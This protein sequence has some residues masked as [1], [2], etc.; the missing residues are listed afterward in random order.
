[1]GVIDPASNKVVSEVLV[2]RD[3]QAIT[4]GAGS[5]WVANVGDETVQ[6]IDPADTAA[7]GATIPVDDYPSDLAVGG[8]SVW[9]ALGALA[10]LVRINP[11][12]NKTASPISALG[13]ETPCGAPRASVAFGGGFV[14]FACEGGAVGRTNARK[15]VS[16]SIASELA[17]SSSSVLPEFSDIA[18][19]LGS[20]WIAN[21]AG[22]RVVELDPLTTQKRQE[23]SVGQAPEAIAVGAD[24]LW[25]AN[26]D[27]DTVT[28]IAI[29]GPGQ[30]ATT[31]EFPVGD[32]PIDV[33]VGEGAVWIVSTLDRKLTRLD[34]ETGDV[35][36]TIALGNE[37]QRVAAGE[38]SVWVSVRA[39][40][41][42]ALESDTTEP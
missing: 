38:G 17:Q 3:P 33:A 5:V 39:P 9:V 21:R 41:E 13:D 11:E 22:N 32:G 20:L 40:E 4:T 10:D 31:T 7:R 15:G 14:W 16:A 35:V 37:P 36:A 2:G 19:G 25:V 27:D 34:P 26:F 8:G 18:F 6:R 28:R 30:T 23:I 24:A 42:D 12:Q 1:V 29:P